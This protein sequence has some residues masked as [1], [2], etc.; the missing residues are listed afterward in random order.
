MKLIGMLGSLAM[1]VM[2]S[3]P[4]AAQGPIAPPGERSEHGMGD[5]GE[6]G[7]WSPHGPRGGPGGHPGGMMGRGPMGRQLI[8]LMLHH[9]SELGLSAAQV[10]SLERLRGDF[11]RD[12]IRRQADQRIAR[13]DL[14]ELMRPDPADPA[15]AVDMA[16]VESKIR[17]IEK[18]SADMRIARIR[19]VEA[20]K[21]QLTPGQRTKLTALLAQHRPQWHRR[22]PEPP[23]P[24][25]S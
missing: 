2:L 24:P 22:G 21:A 5:R 15:K 17:E 13:L 12:A 8:T 20:G 23:P 18:M 10:E 19:A 16:K 9:R 6:P 3:L 7:R 14:M 1:I 11:M 25:R 4:A